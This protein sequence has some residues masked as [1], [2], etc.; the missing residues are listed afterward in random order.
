MH[1]VRSND[2]PATRFATRLAFFASGFGMAS[3]APL[4]P[5]A[6]MRSG[7]DD[8][9]L[10]VA[11]LGFGLGS[12][13]AM[14]LAGGLVSRH[15]SR[16]MI[17]AGGLGL[18]AMLPLLALVTSPWALAVTL[19]V[20]GAAL[21]TIDVAMNVHATE[22]ETAAGMPLMSGFHGMFS[23]GGLA[24]AG[25]GTALLSAG[26]T[27]FLAA[28]AA[29][30]VVLAAIGV[31][32]PRLLRTRPGHT[33]PMFAVPHGMVIV[34]G[35]LAFVAFL[36]EG[37]MLDWSSLFLIHERGV[38]AATAGIGYALFSVAMVAGRFA[39][40][41]LI[42]R[43]GGVR[44]LLAGAALTA[45]GFAWLLLVPIGWLAAAGFL[46]VGLGA[47]TRVP[48]LFSTAGRQTTMPPALA[49][50]SMVTIGYAGVLAGPALI[51]FVA[52]ATSLPTAF[53]MLAVMMLVV[54]AF[55]RIAAGLDGP[56]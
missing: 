49:I 41:G 16:P 29:A 6:K 10:G 3:W 43:L 38:P 48:I 28:L 50:A 55:G 44:V 51:G 35:L 9:G 13:V 2:R 21:G 47:A 32:L 56:R 34:L 25:A 11:L 15:G 24:G 40:D 27:P 18:A 53:V 17:L 4:V 45:A 5:Y 23:L 52:Q 1:D 36:T 33:D 8:A 46:A 22:V 30:A 14:P 42:A 54:P 37:A 20:F 7:L 19:I 12:T 39:G 31:A 26:G